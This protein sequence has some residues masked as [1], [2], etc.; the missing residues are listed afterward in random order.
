MNSDTLISSKQ[1]PSRY[2][3]ALIC[4]LAMTGCAASRTAEAD[5]RDSPPPPNQPVTELPPDPFNPQTFASQYSNPMSCEQQA[6]RYLPSSRDDAWAALK[7]CVDGTHFTLLQALTSRA[8]NSEIRKRPEAAALIAKVIAMRGGSVEGDLRLLN[9]Q[10]LPIFSLAAAMAQP[11]TYKGRYILVRAQ[12]G[13]VRTE[14]EKPTVW[15]VEQ[16]L[17][18]V[19]SEQQVGVAVRKDTASNLAG[20]LSGETTLGGGNVGGSLSKSKSTRDSNT[21]LRYDNISNDT[22]REALGRLPKADPF[23]A[24]GRDF[25]IL[26]RFDGMRTTS[27][28]LDE[29]DEGPRIP[30]LSIV[31]Y[32]I[33]HPLVVY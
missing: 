25:V 10:R 8:W 24:P 13:D 6:R 15:L 5:V 27:G 1:R 22:G 28:A 18:S 29:D 4:A 20:N 12:V 32:Y 3:W 2:A 30:V 7:A 17:G 14:D 11:D 31:S 16:E 21:V 23:L 9:D 19:A 26:A 33:P